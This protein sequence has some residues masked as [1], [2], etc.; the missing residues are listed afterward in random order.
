ME[1]VWGC[2]ATTHTY[3]NTHSDPLTCILWS[4][5][6]EVTAVTAGLAQFALTHSPLRSQPI[7][8]HTHSLWYT[9]DAPAC[10]LFTIHSELV[11]LGGLYSVI[12][13]NTVA[14]VLLVIIQIFMSEHDNDLSSTHT[15][16]LW[17]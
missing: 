1:N 5:T 16:S 2:G 3:L 11:N 10:L 4:L 15:S 6:S 9:Q 12:T 14:F 17:Q 8:I 13:G 7:P